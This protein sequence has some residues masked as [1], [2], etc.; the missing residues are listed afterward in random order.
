MTISNTVG[1]TRLLSEEAQEQLELIERWDPVFFLNHIEEKTAYDANLVERVF[2]LAKER[3]GAI[4]AAACAQAVGP[5]P[6]AWVR[7]DDPR[8]AISDAKKR[9]MIELAGGPGKKLA[10]CYSMPAYAFDRASDAERKDAERYRAFL[11][12]GLPITFCGVEYY[13]K[14]SL[15]AAIDAAPSHEREASCHIS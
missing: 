3:A 4:L 13:D 14:A 9:D 11:K 15:D 5:S 7:A 8:E 2:Q 1:A 10:E 12:A 6:I